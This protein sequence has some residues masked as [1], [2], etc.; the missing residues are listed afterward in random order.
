MKLGQARCLGSTHY[1]LSGVFP[2]VQFAAQDI[3]LFRGFHR[4]FPLLGLSGLVFCLEF[5]STRR[6]GK[7]VRNPDRICSQLYRR[8]EFRDDIQKY[9]YRILL[10][11]WGSWRV[12]LSGWTSPGVPRREPAANAAALAFGNSCNAH[13]WVQAL[14]AFRLLRCRPLPRLAAGTL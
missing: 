13:D 14:L 4:V 12:G 10:K 2:P 11:P 7:P 5:F 8:I 3:R 1:G 6:R 9:G